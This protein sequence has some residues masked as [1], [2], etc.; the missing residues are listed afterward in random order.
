MSDAAFSQVMTVEEAGRQRTPLSI[1]A[2]VAQAQAVADRFGWIVVG[3]LTA[4]LKFDGSGEVIDLSGQ[5]SATVTQ[6][7]VAT[8][9]PVV[10]AVETPFALRLVPA[11]MLEAEGEEAELELDAP[12]LDTVG[13]TGG[14]IDLADIIAETL[15]LS[16]NP[17]PRAANAADWLAEHGVMDEDA[18][19]PFGALAALRE[20]MTKG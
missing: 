2:N 11:A 10:E 16:V 3:S 14:R 9:Q 12:A 7:C 18:A 5:L 17:W 19:G 8:G 13:Y 15:A 1:A 4:V 6:A 20:A